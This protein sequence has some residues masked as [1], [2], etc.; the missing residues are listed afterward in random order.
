MY[1]RITFILFK[2]SWDLGIVMV[3]CKVCGAFIN[4]NDTRIAKL[5]EREENPHLECLENYN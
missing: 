5:E 2:Y 4:E 1:I 3:N